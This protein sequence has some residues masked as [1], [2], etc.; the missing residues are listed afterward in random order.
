MSSEDTTYP[1][2]RLSQPSRGLHFE[3]G[4]VVGRYRI[5]EVIGEGGFG[6]VYRAEQVEGVRRIVALK[7][8]RP[9][10]D[11]GEV[12]ARFEQ[13][14]QALALMDHSNVAK[15]Y[16][17]G[18]T[19]RD[20][21]SLPW[22]A[23][24]YVQ[25]EPITK[26]CDRER[27]T[28]RERV[29]LYVQVCDAVQH[30][31]TKMI[32]HRDI[33]PSNILVRHGGNDGAEVKVIDFGVAKALN[34]RLTERS[35]FTERGQLIGTPEYMSPEQA[36]MSGL[37]IDAR[38]DV[39]SLGVVLY[40]LLTGLL[41]FDPKTLRAAGFAEI[42]R[43]I[44]EVEPPRPSTRLSGVGDTATGFAKARK[45]D[46]RGL[47]SVLRGELDWVVMRCLEKER[48]RRY[49]TASALGEELERYLRNEPVQARPANPGYRLRKF[50]KRRKG[51]VAAGAVIVL[52]LVG[53][54]VGT[55]L[56]MLSARDEAERANSAVLAAERAEALRER[57]QR[58]LSGVFALASPSELGREASAEQILNEAL[59]RLDKE[60][61]DPA[62]SGAVRISI[63]TSLSMLGNYVDALEIAERAYNEI[64]DALGERDLLTIEAKKLRAEILSSLGDFGLAERE[65]KEAIGLAELLL[66]SDDIRLLRMQRSLAIVQRRM[67]QLQAAEDRY[68]DVLAASRR[69][70][71]EYGELTIAAMGDLVSVLIDLGRAEEG[72]ALAREALLRAEGV[73]ARALQVQ[74]VRLLHNGA[75]AAKETGDLELC[76]AWHL[77]AVDRARRV[78]GLDHPLATMV[79][80]NCADT[81]R[82]TGR[83]SD[84]LAMLTECIA[85]VETKRSERE[86]ELVRLLAERAVG[87]VEMGEMEG[88]RRDVVRAKEI[89]TLH[90]VG[91]VGSASEKLLGVAERMLGD[92][93]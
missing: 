84:G 32:L 70:D 86:P 67:G 37:D 83:V 27:L 12:V 56:G 43:V 52:L 59:Q 4:E 85:A 42:Q 92:G 49:G 35:I 23:M 51:P 45:T 74:V 91:R 60:A 19:G 39:Y 38:T 13:E 10:M 63:A 33:K 36:E 78:L 9:G 2:D 93:G 17:G 47:A 25:G 75:Q 55:T 16:D 81:L 79:V 89:A 5:L 31:H 24:E 88:A 21:G 80:G 65:L 73:E 50:V 57:A 15:V 46:L 30:A 3:H 26:F 48:K 18:V 8:I 54:V 6:V 82:R 44:R 20:Q 87:L 68:R 34:Q 53:G 14:R 41:P 66:E 28:L 7:V 40:E 72:V 62:F 76:T 1:A 58:Y 11:S 61:H 77:Q 64:R 69:V 71:G 90:G 22:F 29:A